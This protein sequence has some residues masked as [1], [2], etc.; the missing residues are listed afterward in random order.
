[1]D[2]ALFLAQVIFVVPLFFPLTNELV[3]H[4]VGGVVIGL[5]GAC[6][7]YNLGCELADFLVFLYAFFLVTFDISGEL[8][9]TSLSACVCVA[10]YLI[11]RAFV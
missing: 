10:V 2:T 9:L 8:Y 5:L 6:C 3:T 7:V 4:L 11:Y 1:M